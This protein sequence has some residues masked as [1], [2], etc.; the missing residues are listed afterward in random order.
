[1]GRLPC[2]EPPTRLTQNESNRQVNR[3]QPSP[4]PSEPKKWRD[5]FFDNHIAA[6]NL[7]DQW[8]KAE[9][10][11]IGPRVTPRYERKYT[12]GHPVHTPSVPKNA[13]GHVLVGQLLAKIGYPALMKAYLLHRYPRCEDSRGVPGVLLH[14]GSADGFECKELTVFAKSFG[15]KDFEVAYMLLAREREFI[16]DLERLAGCKP[17]FNRNRNK[18]CAA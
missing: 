7:L 1:M 12:K 17:R 11:E 4:P 8:A 2:V 15:M 5:R 10:G 13:N 14:K 18:E 9:H 16:L 3:M 6:Q